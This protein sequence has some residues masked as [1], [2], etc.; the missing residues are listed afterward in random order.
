MKRSGDSPNEE[1]RPSCELPVGAVGD[2]GDLVGVRNPCLVPSHVSGPYGGTVS[3]L[4][5]RY[6][7]SST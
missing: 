6:A 7:K 1:V 2:R 5:I 3:A 4:V